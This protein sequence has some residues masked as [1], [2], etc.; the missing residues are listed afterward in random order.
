MLESSALDA[1]DQAKLWSLEKMLN[2]DP[3]HK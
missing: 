3:K 1:R 2:M